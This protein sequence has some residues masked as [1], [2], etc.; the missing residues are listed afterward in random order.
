MKR[1]D[2]IQGTEEAWPAVST[3]SRRL[4]DKGL[5]TLKEE[6]PSGREWPFQSLTEFWCWGSLGA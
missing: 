6:T 1:E 3:A 5:S 2:C 4:L